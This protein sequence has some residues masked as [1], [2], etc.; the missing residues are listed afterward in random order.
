MCVVGGGILFIVFFI[1]ILRP[2]ITVVSHYSFLEPLLNKPL[3]IKKEAAIYMTDKVGHRFKQN[4][5]S[6]DMG[7]PNPKIV[8]LPVETVITLKD[9]KTYK[10]NLGS[11]FTSLY[12]LGQ[13]NLPGGVIEFEY[14]WGG[15]DPSLYSQENPLL[16]LAIWQH[17]TE[18]QIRFENE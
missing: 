9:F 6:D 11:G 5:L 14:Y 3:T 7:L 10:S 13:V 16:P 1:F 4:I 8:Q 18:T 2:T 15:T 17:K 12:A